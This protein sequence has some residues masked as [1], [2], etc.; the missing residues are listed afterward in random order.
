[1]VTFTSL[2]PSDVG[3]GNEGLAMLSGWLRYSETGQ[4][5]QGEL[6]KREPES[7]FEEHVIALLKDAGYEAE[8]QIGVNGYFIDIGVKHP[9]YSYGYL[10]GVECDGA[11][12][13]SSRSARDRDRLRQ[14][15]LE[16]LGWHFHRIWSTSWVQ[17]Q[18]T[19]F[20]KLKKAIE[21]RLQEALTERR[22]RR[23]EPVPLPIQTKVAADVGAGGESR[24]ESEHKSGQVGYG[25]KIQLCYLEDDVDNQICTLAKLNER[26]DPSKSVI[27]KESPI[28]EAVWECESGEDVRIQRGDRIYNVKVTILEE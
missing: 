2:K 12:Y 23:K 26:P 6:T 25:T 21:A 11:S 27:S 19:E 1:M 9:D 4:L 14:Q 15:V 7:R 24:R 3:E 10:L 20:D 28:G 22:T 16:G 17:H 5:E 13:H 18:K 8:P